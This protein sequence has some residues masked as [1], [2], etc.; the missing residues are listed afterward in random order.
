[1]RAVKA[2]IV[3][4]VIFTVFSLG[5]FGL[6]SAFSVS[7]GAVVAVANLLT[8]R[9]IVRALLRAPEPEAE[10][11]D[12]P[13]NDDHEGAGRR[14]GAAWGIFAVLKL[15][16]L[17][18]GIG[19]L[20]TTGFVDPMPLVVGYGVLPLGIALSSLWSNLSPRG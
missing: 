1:M 19:I 2:A 18:G 8:L 11:E 20:L 4:G 14:G 15:V 10:G 6:K 16:V 17:F 7:I 12:Q 5:L 3:L 13:D 9:A